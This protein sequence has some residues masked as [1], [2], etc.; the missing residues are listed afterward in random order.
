MN[1]AARLLAG[2]GADEATA[3]PTLVTPS[4][5]WTRAELADRSAR[6]AGA[7][8]ATAAPGDRVA[9]LADNDEHFIAAYLGVLISGRVAVPLNP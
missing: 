3:R 9:I 5:S 1:L 8:S 2:S 7:V 6:V 4:V